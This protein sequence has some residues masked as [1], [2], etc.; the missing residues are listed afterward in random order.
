MEFCRPCYGG[1]ADREGAVFQAA[2]THAEENGC[3]LYGSRCWCMMLMPLWPLIRK[4]LVAALFLLLSVCCGFAVVCRMPCFNP[5]V[6]VSESGAVS[7]LDL[8]VSVADAANKV[9]TPLMHPK[10]QQQKAIGTCST[11][12]APPPASAQISSRQSSPNFQTHPLPCSQQQQR[13]F[14]NGKHQSTPGSTHL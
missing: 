14:Q 8:R 7:L 10:F 5:A 4:I 13:K 9:F 3:W 12:T 1:N 11:S 2:D 6:C